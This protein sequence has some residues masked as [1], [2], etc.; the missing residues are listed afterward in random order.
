MSHKH[1][2]ILLAFIV[3]GAIGGV[4][5]GWYFGTQAQNIA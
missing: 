4:L 3:S 2:M 1:A 5:Y